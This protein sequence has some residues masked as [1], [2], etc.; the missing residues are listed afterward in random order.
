M[1]L[2]DVIKVKYA[3]SFMEALTCAFTCLWTVP[4]IKPFQVFIKCQCPRTKKREVLPKELDSG[5][6]MTFILYL[7]EKS[8]R[9]SFCHV[10]E[11]K[12]EEMR[13]QINSAVKVSCSPLFTRDSP[14]HVNSFDLVVVKSNVWGRNPLQPK[15]SS[16]G[17]SCWRGQSQDLGGAKTWWS[18]DLGPGRTWPQPGLGRSHMRPDVGDNV[19]F[20]PCWIPGRCTFKPLCKCQSVSQVIDLRL[21]PWHHTLPA[22]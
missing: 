11:V 6:N 1:D 10:C 2:W 13:F 22:V 7:L 20:P 9:L 4:V 8:Q 14:E 21:R 19:S 15:P 18:K 16:W 5:N 12:N 3:D 17:H